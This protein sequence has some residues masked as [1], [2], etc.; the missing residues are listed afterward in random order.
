MQQRLQHVTTIH[1][2]CYE[3]LRR[4]DFTA[5][6]VY[7]ILWTFSRFHTFVVFPKH[8]HTLPFFQRTKLS[9]ILFAKRTK[10]TLRSPSG[11]VSQRLCIETQALTKIEQGG[12]AIRTPAGTSLNNAAAT[13]PS[14]LELLIL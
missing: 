9:H 10:Y 13:N 7:G 6:D 8:S 12:P 14:L 5:V 1:N 11:C 3:M 2:Q 4:V